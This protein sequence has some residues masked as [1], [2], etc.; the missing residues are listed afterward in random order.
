MGVLLAKKERGTLLVVKWMVVAKLLTMKGFSE[1]YV[2]RTMSGP[3]ASIF[4]RL[5]LY[6]VSL[7]CLH[8]A[9]KGGLSISCCLIICS[10]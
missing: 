7:V 4:A 9:E 8:V 6:V 3:C 2:K 1:E 10:S 5:L